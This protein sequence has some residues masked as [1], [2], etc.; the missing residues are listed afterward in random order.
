MESRRRGDYAPAVIDF[1]AHDFH[2]VVDLPEGYDVRDFTVPAD[3][4]APRTSPFDI[5]KYDEDRLIYTQDLFDGAE[6]RTVHVGLDIGGPVGTPVHAFAE[7][8]VVHAG[9]N[10]ADGDYGHTL[11][12]HHVLDGIDLYCLLGHLDAQTLVD[13]PVGRAF[14]AGD[15]LGRLGAEHEN[16]G[17]PAHVHIQLSWE[18]PATYDLP[19]VVTRAEREDA[20]KRFPDPRLVLGPLY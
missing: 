11:V 14:S 9:Y 16:G 1:D 13:S 10:A 19:G 6:R 17:W 4:R 2:P 20:L 3:Q 15:V 12:T 5:G 8:V 18:R 7:G